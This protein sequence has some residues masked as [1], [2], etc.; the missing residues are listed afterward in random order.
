M[1]LSRPPVITVKLCGSHVTF[2][3]TL[4]AET[5]PNQTK[6]YCTDLCFLSTATSCGSHKSFGWSAHFLL[7]LKDFQ[8]TEMPLRLDLCKDKQIYSCPLRPLCTVLSRIHFTFSI[9]TPQGSFWSKSLLYPHDTCIICGEWH[10]LLVWMICKEKN[11]IFKSQPRWYLFIYDFFIYN[12]QKFCLD[13]KQTYH[14]SFWVQWIV[15]AFVS[16]TNSDNLTLAWLLLESG[17]LVSW[18]I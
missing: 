1:Q 14:E 4:L 6:P 9:N 10:V 3:L 12:S 16:W 13:D 18:L 5:K 17:C 8:L 11:T 7:R 15:I 2:P